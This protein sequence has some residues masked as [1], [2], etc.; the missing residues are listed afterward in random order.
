M[1]TISEAMQVYRYQ[2]VSFDILFEGESKPTVLPSDYINALYME[3][4]YDNTYFPIIWTKIVLDTQLYF[5]II[6]NKSTVK[7]R[8]RLQ[9]FVVNTNDIR[10][11]TEITDREN[12][13][14][15]TFVLLIDEDTPMI[16]VKTT[17]EMNREDKGGKN[18][19]NVGGKEFTFFLFN[20]A[21][22]KASSTLL[23]TVINNCTMSDVLA[24]CLYTT[25][26]KNVLMSPLENKTSHNSVLLPPFTLVGNL[27]Y[28]EAYYGF[29]KNGLLA[30]FDVP[31]SY[32]IDM[33]SKCTAWE[34]G[35]VKQTIFTIRS[36]ED[37]YSISTGSFNDEK[38]F[39]INVTPG[40]INMRTPSV[41]SDQL[42]GNNVYYIDPASA[43]LNTHKSKANQRGDGS[44][45]VVVDKYDNMYNR[46]AQAK[47][48]E[49]MSQIAEINIGDFDI[50]A[51]SPNK[52]FTLVFTNSE[53]TK[54]HG[55]N[56][57]M[58]YSLIS[59]TKE[60]NYMKLSAGLL[61]KKN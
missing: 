29:Y 37:A 31:R 58:A 48:I 21:H 35:E 61:V 17:T 55:G 28:L 9:K 22:L 20:E 49:E 19:H 34:R 52:E 51:I 8:I 38:A 7:F 33:Q 41:S 40:N 50:D 14:N 43:D 32:M 39:Q 16:D 53:L 25:G 15:E 2:I 36:D 5:K 6:Q 60:G 18:P 13:F 26:V 42:V 1:S 46:S 56:Y 54:S 59:F 11:L 3:K 24:Y 44:F 27:E 47:R 4:D 45:R 10:N 23:N 12:V 30:F 57:R